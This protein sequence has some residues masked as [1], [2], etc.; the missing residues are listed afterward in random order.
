MC[1]DRDVTVR[2]SS[3]SVALCWFWAEEEEEEEEVVRMRKVRPLFGVILRTWS[4]APGRDFLHVE[5]E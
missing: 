1:S 4:A 2:G 3:Y 5:K